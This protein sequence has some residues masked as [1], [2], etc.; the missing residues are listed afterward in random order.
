MYERFLVIILAV[1]AQTLHDDTELRLG[2]V[3][4]SK[5]LFNNVVDFRF[6]LLPREILH[7]LLSHL[8]G[9]SDKSCDFIMQIEMSVK[10]VNVS[11]AV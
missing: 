4:I 11:V 1:I 7:Y 8:M 5:C 2:R 6:L 3:A 10:I 9:S